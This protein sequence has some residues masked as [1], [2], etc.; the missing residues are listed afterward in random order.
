M[1]SCGPTPKKQRD[2]RVIDEAMARF[3]KKGRS[4]RKIKKAPQYSKYMTSPEW[5]EKRQEACE[6]LG[7]KCELCYSDEKVYVHHNNYECLGNEMPI[8]DLAVL[9]RKCHQ[10]FHKSTK[11]GEMKRERGKIPWIGDARL[12]WQLKKQHKETCRLC[13][14]LCIRDYRIHEAPQRKM[15]ICSTCISKYS[16]NILREK[17]KIINQK[18]GK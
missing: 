16:D 5:N 7:T 9:C 17:K 2:R 12:Y 4:V 11:A 1:S 14:R 8:E 3:L 6:I 10:R 15:H 13:G 18:G